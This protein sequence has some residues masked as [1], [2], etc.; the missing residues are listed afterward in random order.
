MRLPLTM[1][2]VAFKSSLPSEVQ[3]CADRFSQNR[4]QR[5]LQWKSGNC[6]SWRGRKLSMR[7][8]PVQCVPPELLSSRMSAD[9][10]ATH[11][12]VQS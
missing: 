10:Q 9:G 2:M 3:G 11:A 1:A 8:P 12:P 6:A 7:W 4:T 5:Q